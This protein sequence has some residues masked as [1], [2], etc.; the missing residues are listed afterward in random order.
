MRSSQFSPLALFL[1]TY[2]HHVSLAENVPSAMPSSSSST[3]SS[4]PTVDELSKAAALFSGPIEEVA[5]HPEFK[6]LK[7]LLWLESNQYLLFSNVKWEDER[8]AMCGMIWKYSDANGVEKFRKCSGLIGSGDEP[9]NLDDYLEAGSNGLV[10]GW[11][12]D[13]DLLICQHGKHRIVRINVSD[14]QADAEQ[15]GSI[16]S[17]LVTILADAYNNTMLN[18]PNDMFLYGSDLYFTDPPFGLQLASADNAFSHAFEIMPQN[19]SIYIISGDPGDNVTA[20]PEKVLDFG[21]PDHPYGPNGVIVVDNGD[22]ITPITDF[23]DPHIEV[24][25]EKDPDVFTRLETEYSIEGENADYPPLNDGATYSS[26]LNVVFS[27]SPGGI[28]MYDASDSYKFLGFLRINDLV[29]NVEIG[30]GY[31]W[32]TANRR[33]LRIPLEQKATTSSPSANAGETKSPN[34]SGASSPSSAPNGLPSSKE[35]ASSATFVANFALYSW[36]AVMSLIVLFM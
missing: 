20:V 13:G 22:L 28:Y 4:F 6:W 14:V 34:S 2:T 8:N 26:D 19:P 29:S 1:Q 16:D 23:S 10:W 5:T 30:G 32:M 17:S 35:S 12:G 33:L 15:G 25:S 18:S 3:P 21:K 31:L 7:S 24:Y 36:A 9:E 11:K 27:T